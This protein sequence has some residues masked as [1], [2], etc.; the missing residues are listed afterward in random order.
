MPTP[1]QDALSAAARRRGV[2]VA[3]AKAP[4]A[5]PDPAGPPAKKA[6][7]NNQKRSDTAIGAARVEIDELLDKHPELVFGTLH[8]LK[9]QLILKAR[10]FDADAGG[11]E[12][13]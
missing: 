11:G 5:P 3:F 1:K 4:G 7:K 13:R 6:K 2:R 9:T 8:D 10:G 12:A